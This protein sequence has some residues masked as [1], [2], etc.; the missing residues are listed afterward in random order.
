[1]LCT[2]WRY[3]KAMTERYSSFWNDH[4][5]YVAIIRKTKYRKSIKMDSE[6]ACNAYRECASKMRLLVNK[7]KRAECQQYISSLEEKDGAKAIEKI[8]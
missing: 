5:E 8:S 7:R 1:M 6:E 3:K 2:P 4:L